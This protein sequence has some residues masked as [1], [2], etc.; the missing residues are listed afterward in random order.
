MDATVQ[1]DAEQLLWRSVSKATEWLIDFVFPPTCGNCGLVD[2]RYCHAC[3]QDLANVPIIID[4][5]L[6]DGI[7]GLCATGKHT[8]KL[9][10]ALQAFK[11]EGAIELAGVLAT[12]L[13]ATLQEQSWPI[14]MIVP[15]PLY[16]DRLLER[17]YNQSGLLSEIVEGA[18]RLP[19][20]PECLSRTRD[21]SQ[22]A[23]LNAADR[24]QNVKY[25]FAASAAAKGQS[26]LLI[27]DV[28]TTGS[29]LSECADALRATG[30]RAVYAIAVSHA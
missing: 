1:S 8:G 5:R 12:R 17:G 30:A 28:V 4:H 20:R 9:Q 23:G 2:Y 14:D 13:V 11:Y 3:R 15:V 22:Q 16:A 10:R 18:M 27:D 7:D 25:A 29:T 21:T 24:M 26:I 6:V 19:C